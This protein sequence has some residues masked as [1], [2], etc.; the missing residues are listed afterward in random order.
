METAYQYRVTKYNPRFRNRHGGY[1]VDDWVCVSQIG[2]AFG[3]VVLTPER[4]QQV[5]SAYATVAVAFMKE[6]GT[7]ALVA[8]GIENGE[9]SPFAP[10]RGGVV[11]GGVLEDVARRL[12]RA[13]F[14]CRLE[15]DESFI[16]IGY[17][18][19]MYIGVPQACPQSCAFARSVGLFVE[20]FLS[21]YRHQSG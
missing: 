10:I 11:S 1:T 19:Y 14:W 6:A 21:P 7:T 5:E 2:E 20:P 9:K 13:E 18:Y 8:L 16:H 15:A 12:L 3:G 4:Y 17:D